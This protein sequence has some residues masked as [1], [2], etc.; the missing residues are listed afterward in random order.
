MKE[1]CGRVP[2]KGQKFNLEAVTGFTQFNLND[3]NTF[4]C[5]QRNAQG[6]PDFA[7]QYLEDIPNKYCLRI[8]YNVQ[9]RDQDV[10]GHK[11]VTYELQKFIV[12]ATDQQIFQSWFKGYGGANT[13]TRT[14]L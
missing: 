3:P 8:A 12:L 5:V 10:K 9:M 6:T 13:C 11:Q 7:K 2:L 1:K 4:G 14:L